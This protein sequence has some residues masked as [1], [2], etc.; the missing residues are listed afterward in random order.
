MTTYK[1]PYIKNK[2]V[3]IHKKKKSDESSLKMYDNY[4]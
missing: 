4:H 1:K 2:L 3:M